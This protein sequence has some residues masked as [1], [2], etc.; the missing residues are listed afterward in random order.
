MT[1]TR[2]TSWPSWSR[3]SGP[4]PIA[5]SSPATGGTGEFL[6][7]HP[8]HLGAIGRLGLPRL[9]H[10]VEPLLRN[11]LVDRLERWEMDRKI[12]RLRVASATGEV[13]FDESICKGH[14][15]GY[16]QQVLAAFDARLAERRQW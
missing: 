16:R 5:S 15:E 11:R 2:R 8:G 7:N 10:T 6:P 3:C 1:S 4:R 12:A 14:F 9:H 13:R